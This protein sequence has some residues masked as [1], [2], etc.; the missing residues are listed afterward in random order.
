MPFIL[1]WHL[2]ML[3][4]FL[5]AMLL[6]FSLQADTNTDGNKYGR[7]FG[8]LIFSYKDVMNYKEY[9]YY[10]G[11]GFRFDEQAIKRMSNRSIGGSSIVGST[12]GRIEIPKEIKSNKVYIKVKNPSGAKVYING[13]GVNNGNILTSVN[14]DSY[15]NR[16]VN[17]K[18]SIDDSKSYFKDY[19]S[20]RIP[21]IKIEIVDPHREIGEDFKVYDASRVYRQK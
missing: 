19:I 6:V 13:T 17:I 11:S 9:I 1:V 21:S 2:K 5:V 15:G 8:K 12:E 14:K 18:L 16:Y 7:V 3:K 10:T 20:S 4:S